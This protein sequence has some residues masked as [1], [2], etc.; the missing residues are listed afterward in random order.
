MFHERSDF[1]KKQ[2]ILPEIKQ[3]MYSTQF[4]PRLV[5]L[6]QVDFKSGVLF[7]K[8]NKKGGRCPP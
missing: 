6:E 3:N 4:N 2:D 7:S 8:Y 5:L 1:H